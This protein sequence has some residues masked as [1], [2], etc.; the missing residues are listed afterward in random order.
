MLK[1]RVITALVLVPLI[2]SLVLYRD[3][4]VFLSVSGIAFIIAGWEWSLLAGIIKPAARLIYIFILLCVMVVSILLEAIQDYIIFVSVFWWIAAIIGILFIKYWRPFLD[5]SGTKLASG[6]LIL[7]SAWL[8]L[9]KLHAEFDYP[10]SLL[11]YLFVLIWTADIA[12][13]FCG[14]YWGKNKLASIISPGK[15]R[16]GVYGA[17][18]MCMLLAVIYFSYINLDLIHIVYFLVLSVFTVCMS[19]VGD[20]TE[21]IFKRNAGLK[22]SGNILPGHGGVL[23]RIDSLTAAAPIYA[24]G[25]WFLQG[26]L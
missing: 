13:Y 10:L 19:V 2:V 15:T 6:I 12:A 14:K 1:T 5:L 17:L 26:K 23:D 11:L 9:V 4:T 16:E 7:V 22:D 18:V 8:S 25:L 24:V 20:L 3:T 21:S